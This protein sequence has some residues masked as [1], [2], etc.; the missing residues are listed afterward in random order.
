MLRRVVGGLGVAPPDGD[1]NGGMEEDWGKENKWMMSRA[2]SRSFGT[3]DRMRLG[4]TERETKRRAR[5]KMKKFH[6]VPIPSNRQSP[7][8]S[9]NGDPGTQTQIPRSTDPRSSHSV[10]AGQKI[11]EN[12]NAHPSVTEADHFADGSKTHC[13][14]LLNSKR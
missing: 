10:T 4:G 13:E 12:L 3:C 5:R 7:N 8:G 9:V 6:Q 1:K 11:N 2:L 14:L